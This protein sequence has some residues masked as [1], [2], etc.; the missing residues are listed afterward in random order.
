MRMTDTQLPGPCSSK[1]KTKYSREQ[2]PGGL[3]YLVVIDKIE[4]AVTGG[5]FYCH[6]EGGD[7]IAEAEKI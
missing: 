1:D 4:V 5:Y 2:K 3:L 7:A 6:Y